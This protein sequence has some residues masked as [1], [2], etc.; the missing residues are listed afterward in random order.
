LL[1]PLV[2]RLSTLLLPWKRTLSSQVHQVGLYPLLQN[3]FSYN[4]MRYETTHA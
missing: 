2:L 1:S 4:S 3:I